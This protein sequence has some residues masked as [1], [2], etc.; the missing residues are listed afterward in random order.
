LA[1]S[2]QWAILSWRLIGAALRRPFSSLLFYAESAILFLV[3]LLP[4]APTVA[5]RPSLPV[6]FAPLYVAGLFL[7]GG[8]LGRWG[9]IHAE[10]FRAMETDDAA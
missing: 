8:L 4:I 3:V 6:L 2:S 7:Y 9:W 1:A 10:T 5:I